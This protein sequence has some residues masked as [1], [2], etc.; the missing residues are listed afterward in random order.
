MF[1]FCLFLTRKVAID[2]ILVEAVI[3]TLSAMVRI[4]TDSISNR[5]AFVIGT[6]IP[7]RVTRIVCVAVVLRFHDSIQGGDQQQEKG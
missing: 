2:T 4:V 5:L 1:V 3:T 6:E 7:S